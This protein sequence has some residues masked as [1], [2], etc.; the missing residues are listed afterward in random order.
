MIVVPALLHPAVWRQGKWARPVF[1]D[2]AIGWLIALPSLFALTY[3]DYGPRMFGGHSGDMTPERLLV[4]SLL[5]GILFG[6]LGLGV[7]LVVRLV[8][9]MA[10]KSGEAPA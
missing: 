8:P 3:R 4:G 7:A 9:R 5:A 1:R 2:I 6:L 10:R